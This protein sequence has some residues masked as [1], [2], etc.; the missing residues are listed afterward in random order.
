MSTTDPLFVVA[1]N[2]AAY[3]NWCQAKGHAP[4]GG[5]VRYVRGIETLAHLRSDVRFLFLY[6]WDQRKDWRAIHNRAL[7]IGRRP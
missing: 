7:V 2:Y 4:H 6:G 5:S 1:F 3:V